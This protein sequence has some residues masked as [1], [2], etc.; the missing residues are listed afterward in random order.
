MATIKTIKPAGG[1]DYTTLQA[2][3][4]WADDQGS[5]A[6]W[7]ECYT[8]GNLGS[9]LIQDW[10]S[11]PSGVNYPRIYTDLTERHE[12]KD[13]GAGAYIYRSSGSGSGVRVIYTNYVRVEGLRI[14]YVSGANGNPLSIVD[15]DQVVFD[16]NLI[17][18]DVGTGIKGTYGLFNIVRNNIVVVKISQ[19]IQWIIQT[20]SQVIIDNNTVHN[21]GTADAGIFLESDAPGFTM[22][23]AVRNNIVTGGFSVG[24]YTKDTD[25]TLA[26]AISNNLSSDATADDWGGS[27]NLINKS[28][29][30][31]FVNVASDWNLKSGADALEAGVTIGTFD[32]D[33]LHLDA[34][35]WRPQGSVWDMGALEKLLGSPVSA[36]RNIPKM[37]FEKIVIDRGIPISGASLYSPV[38]SDYALPLDALMRLAESRE[39]PIGSGGE[40]IRAD[41]AMGISAEGIIR[42]DRTIPIWSGIDFYSY[43]ICVDSLG[44]IPADRTMPVDS[45]LRIKP[46]RSIPVDAMGPTIGDRTIP[47]GILQHIKNDLATP[48]D[49]LLGI[50]MDETIPFWAYHDPAENRVLGLS[51]FERIQQDREIPMATMLRVNKPV[52]IP[53]AVMSNLYKDI[54]ILVNVLQGIRRER[55]IHAEAT[56]VIPAD[57]TTPIDFL[58]G[59]KEDA[60]IPISVRG[61]AA[62]DF[63]IPIGIAQILQKDIEIAAE[64]KQ[65]L[66]P[67]RIFPVDAVGQTSND[68]ELL[69]HS[70]MGVAPNRE[71]RAEATG[72][73]SADRELITEWLERIAL[74]I[75]LRVDPLEGIAS[76]AEINISIL[77]EQAE[78]A[79]AADRALSLAI[80]Q[81]LK[82]DAIL[83]VDA[84]QKL[85]ADV[86]LLLDAMQ[87]LVADH[88]IPIDAKY[89]GVV[90]LSRKIRSLLVTNGV[91][92][93]LWKRGG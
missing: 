85:E 37:I 50:R 23:G 68:I 7:A 77:Q 54:D 93:T 33:A 69:V 64:A 46:D 65:L 87:E 3:E 18:S 20:N 66:A 78:V 89:G 9:C 19:G 13:T 5:A 79:V 44:G 59:L 72:Y 70:L 10:I 25:I 35:N 75:D 49:I 22:N 52:T 60:E 36:D 15:S 51:V 43:S 28:A 38:T 41:R 83:P 45:G 56:S 8:G 14:K 47:I 17:L 84:L 61:W 32:W 82:E 90:I 31:Q 48:V 6:Q 4:D 55:V 26:M 74:D 58:T 91:Y 63:S 2:W 53:I 62:A 39:V 12:G 86:T 76:D 40:F 11:S 67:D 80:I 27:G 30:N 24:D 81:E 21:N 42:V 1:G 29:A 34:D 71:L 88:T 57:R 92:A 16:S 73:V